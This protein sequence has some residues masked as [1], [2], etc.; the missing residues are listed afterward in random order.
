MEPVP[1]IQLKRTGDYNPGFSKKP[2]LCV[3]AGLVLL[4]TSGCVG[5][6]FLHSG[7]GDAPT[8]SKVATSWNN[9]VVYAPDPT[10]GGAPEPYLMGRMYLFGPGDGSIVAAAGSVIVDLFDATP[11]GPGTEPVMLEELRLD[12]ETLRK[13]VKE[14]TFGKGYSLP[15]VWRTYRPDIAQV[16]MIVR[17]EPLKGQPL[18]HQSGNM[19]IDHSATRDQNLAQFKAQAQQSAKK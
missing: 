5:K 15:F 14:D 16:N 2:G 17:F 12:P 10:R 19:A 13:L 1:S 3:L 8:L 6:N 7:K 18:I 11:R 9:K 4:L